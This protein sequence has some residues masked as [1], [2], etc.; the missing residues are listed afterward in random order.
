MSRSPLLL[1]GTMQRVSSRCRVVEPLSEWMELKLDLAARKLSVAHGF[2]LTDV[3][4]DE[5]ICHLGRI[6]Y[7]FML[8]FWPDLDNTLCSFASLWDSAIGK[9]R[10]SVIRCAA[11]EL[12][13]TH[14]LEQAVL[15]SVQMFACISQ[16]LALTFDDRLSAEQLARMRLVQDHLR[17]CIF[18]K[19]DPELT[20][21]RAHS[22]SGSEPLLAEAAYFAMSQSAVDMTSALKASLVDLPVNATDGAQLVMCLLLILAR[23][24]AV[25]EP[26]DFGH[27]A[28]G[29]HG[30]SGRIM[31]ALVFF[32]A[33]FIF[34]DDHSVTHDSQ[35]RDREILEGQCDTIKQLEEHLSAFQMYFNHFIPVL[36]QVLRIDYLTALLAR[37]AAARCRKHGYPI[38]AILTMVRDGRVEQGSVALVLLRVVQHGDEGHDESDMFSAMDPYSLDILATDLPP[39]EPLVRIVFALDW[40]K[41][42]GSYRITRRK[43]VDAQQRTFISYDIWITG[44]APTVLCPMTPSREQEMREVLL[45]TRAHN[46]R[47]SLRHDRG[48]Y[49]TVGMN[50]FSL[51]VGA[52]VRPIH[53]NGWTRDDWS[54]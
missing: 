19:I 33:L 48:Q 53:W 29:R 39:V 49:V 10:Q 25:G 14:H 1:S 44:L 31:D 11:Q 37:G 22:H 4:S 2:T 36:P 41:G 47:L 6:G 26:D 18:T 52:D 13:H 45:L 24:A 54:K 17:L 32:R 51:R 21:L 38:D 15:S 40:P 8:R 35:Y 3:T 42:T 16:R 12:L 34:M 5:Y 9:W 50:S 20:A 27:P 46:T 30:R 23:D 43:N 7:D 28:P